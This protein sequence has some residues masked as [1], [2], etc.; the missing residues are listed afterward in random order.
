[1]KIAVA[2]NDFQHFFLQSMS[3]KYDWAFDTRKTK[4]LSNLIINIIFFIFYIIFRDVTLIISHRN[5]RAF[6]LAKA[7]KKEIKTEYFYEGTCFL[8][9]GNFERG[10]WLNE[11]GIKMPLK[12]LVG[13]ADFTA[14]KIYIPSYLIG[15]SLF[16]NEV[17]VNFKRPNKI[18]SEYFDIYNLGMNQSEIPNFLIK[19]YE[20]NSNRFSSSSYSLLDHSQRYKCIERRLNKKCIT[21]GSFSSVFFN[22]RYADGDIGLIDFLNIKDNINLYKLLINKLELNYIDHNSFKVVFK[23]RYYPSGINHILE[24]RN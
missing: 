24:I 12:H 7:I 4:P 3:A 8:Q 23:K 20:K 21:I 13:K 1:M 15:S 9:H 22:L 17:S 2:N 16:S 11:E 10:Y 18:D 19:C 14:S 6:K 5:S